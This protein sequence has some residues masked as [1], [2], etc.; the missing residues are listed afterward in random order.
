[1]LISSGVL[2]I[3]KTSQDVPRR[4]LPPGSSEITLY[5]RSRPTASKRPAEDADST[6]SERSLDREASRETC[7]VARARQHGLILLPTTTIFTTRIVHIGP[8]SVLLH[9]DLP[10]IVRLTL[11]VCGDRDTRSA[12]QKFAVPSP[13]RASISSPWGGQGASQRQ[14]SDTLRAL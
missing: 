6:F 3:S 12:W 4:H 7:S 5:S 14:G 1:M 10:R 13:C 9:L 8:S 11:S 2:K